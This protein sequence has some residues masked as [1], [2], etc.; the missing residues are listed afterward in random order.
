MVSDSHFME[1]MKQAVWTKKIRIGFNEISDER[2]LQ[3]VEFLSHEH[4]L[5]PILIGDTD[6][7]EE[8]LQKYKIDLPEV[9]IFDP[10]KYLGKREYVQKL[11]TLR[12]EKGM[13]LEQAKEKVETTPYF[14]TLLL[15]T[16]EIDGLVSGAV[17]TTA[18]VLLPAFE[19]IGTAEKATVASSF[20]IM[21]R[22]EEFL[23]FA[24]CGVNIEPDA[25]TLADIAI[26]S[27]DSC[28]LFGFD[29]PKVALLSFSTKGSATY[30]GSEKIRNAVSIVQKK[31][32]EITID[33]EL[34]FDAAYVPAIAN[35]KAP[36][37]PIKGNAT[38]FIFPDLE[39]GNIA[40]KIAE[41]LG[42]YQAL[43]PI[44]QGLTK[45]VTD[46]S[47]GCSTNDIICASIMTA[48]MALHKKN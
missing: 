4:L 42:G 35:R 31:R 33:G 3:A 22:G 34:Q 16:D 37:S 24:D 23:F 26:Q 41:H 17:H 13:T 2:V 25:E 40:Y 27:Y 10:A 45:Q 1:R 29:K 48:Y 15:S 43:G 6:T 8:N 28:A 39:A 46:L 20:F 7:I 11:Y 9:H 36:Q 14:S 5:V 18:D 21:R 47:R 19:I 12:K 30:S 44:V 38:V 32:P